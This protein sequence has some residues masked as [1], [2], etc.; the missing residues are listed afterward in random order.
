MTTETISVHILDKDY[1]VAC[2]SDER[3]ALSRAASELDRRMREIRQSGTVIG[4]ERIAVMAALNL[5]YELFNS[6]GQH[7]ELDQTLVEDMF[8]RID[9]ALSH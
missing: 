5:A 1:Q 8:R 9:T 4:V 2:P 6:S 3:D 7:S